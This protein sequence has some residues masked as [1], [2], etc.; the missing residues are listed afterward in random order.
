MEYF[1]NVLHAKN[2][3]KVF[4]A[5]NGTIKATISTFAMERT[6]IAWKRGKQNVLTIRT[7]LV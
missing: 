1:Q 2:P 4:C 7:V 5:I 3:V 6:L